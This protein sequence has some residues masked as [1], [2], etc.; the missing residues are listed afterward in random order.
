VAEGGG[1]PLLVRQAT[2][3]NA[4]GLHARAAARFVKTAEPFDARVQVTKDDASAGGTSIL[5]LMLLAAGTGTVLTLSA[6][7]PD[8]E[9][10]L[11]VLVRLV[12]DRFGESS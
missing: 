4:K 3:V 9:A 2:I 10:A 5:G 12:E 7:G 6:E 11:D 1:A 8:A